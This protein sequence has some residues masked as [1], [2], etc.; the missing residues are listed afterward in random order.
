MSWAC[1][2]RFRVLLH[3]LE[4]IKEKE[5]L[6]DQLQTQ[7]I[8]LENFVSFLQKESAAN[9]ANSPIPTISPDSPNPYSSTRALQSINRNPPKRQTSM[10]GLIGAKKFEKNELKNTPRGN[11]YG[12]QRAQLEI[13]VND[14]I[15]ILKKYSIVT[16]D[17]DEINTIPQ[18]DEQRNQELFE[19]SEEEVVSVFRKEFCPALR[20]LLEHGM[21]SEVSQS[22]SLMGL[23][24]FG[25][26][27]DRT[28]KAAKAAAAQSGSHSSGFPLSHV[29]DV[30]LY[31]YEDRKHKE[32]NDG[33][34]GK[35]SQTFKLDNVS[36]KQITSK[37]KI[38]EK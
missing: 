13:I 15:E 11:H 16:L 7:I 34:V 29:W 26:F 31:F 20:A 23:G 33:S 9:C 21:K 3:I 14:V 35:L 17:L 28:A 36:G 10:F 2:I 4:P 38:F 8:D 30:V 27:P 6:V 24:V 22:S 37:E 1:G 32:L 19:W 18:D 12:D 25:C 5:Q